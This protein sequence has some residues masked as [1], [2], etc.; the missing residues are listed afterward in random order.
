MDQAQDEHPKREAQRRFQEAVRA[1]QR[2][3]LGIGQAEDRVKP[4]GIHQLHVGTDSRRPFDAHADRHRED[5]DVE[6]RRR[7]AEP[8]HEQRKVPADDG[9]VPERVE[10]GGIVHRKPGRGHDE[11]KPE[12]SGGLQVQLQLPGPEAE[13]ISPAQGERQGVDDVL[14]RASFR[15]SRPAGSAGASREGPDQDRCEQDPGGPNGHQLIVGRHPACRHEGLQ[16]A[17]KRAQDTRPEPGA[18]QAAG[19][20]LKGDEAYPNAP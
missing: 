5:A 13:P 2:R 7:R 9:D 11:V 6:N 4:F 18:A 12:R 20:T 3:A 8:E 16:K 17:A 19:L 14:A 1:E 15:Q 10:T